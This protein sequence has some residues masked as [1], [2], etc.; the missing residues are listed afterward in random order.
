MLDHLLK[1][2]HM[3]LLAGSVAVVIVLIIL[4]RWTGQRVAMP[5]ASLAL[6]G[7]GTFDY[8]IAGTQAHQP[9][10]ARIAGRRPSDMGEERVAEL[11][12]SVTETGQP[13]VIAVQVEGAHVGDIHGRDIPHFHAATG[14]RVAA[15]N[16]VVLKEKGVLTVRLD[17]VWPPRLT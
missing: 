8:G 10:L 3:T 16:A 9:A 4:L 11:V 2:D 1:A 15:C 12:A 6:K 17:V 7:D 5:R 14:G 13:S